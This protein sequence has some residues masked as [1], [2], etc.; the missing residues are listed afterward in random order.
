[1]SLWKIP[2]WEQLSECISVIGMAVFF[3]LFPDAAMLFCAIDTDPSDSQ[4]QLPVP[5]G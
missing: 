3:I 2:G 5:C 1:M 4:S